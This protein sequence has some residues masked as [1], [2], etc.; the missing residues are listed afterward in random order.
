MCPRKHNGKLLRKSVLLLLLMA[1]PGFVWGQ[2]KKA[3]S[4]PAPRPSAPAQHAPAQHPPAPA[5]AAAPAHGAPARPGNAAPR[6]GTSK[7]AATKPGTTKPGATPA[8]GAPGARNSGTGNKAAGPGVKPAAP[9]NKPGTGTKTAGPGTKPGGSS[10]KS[11]VKQVSLR[12]GGTARVRSNGQIRSVNRNGMH[13]EHNLHGGRTVVS[14]RGGKR[15][16]TTG[17]HGGYVQKSYMTRGGHSYYSRTYYDHGHYR[18]GVY[19]GY[20]YRGYHYYGYHP[21][22]YYNPGF[23][24]WAGRPWGAPVYWGV[25]AWGWGGA[26]WYA[27]YGFT[28][29]ASYPGPAFWLTDYLIAANLQAAYA[30][31]GAG[32]PALPG[33]VNQSEG[34]VGADQ[35]NVST[36]AWNGRQYEMTFN[37][38]HCGNLS[39]VRWNSDGVVLSRVDFNGF[40]ATYTGKLQ[41]SGAIAGN[42]LWVAP[43]TSG[44]VGAWSATF[45]PVAPAPLAGSEPVALSPEVKQAVAEEV[46]AQL[47]AE[48]ATAGQGS[49]GA[50][51]SQS[52]GDE[53][54]PALDPARRTFVVSADLAVDDTD[55]QECSL[56]QGDVLMRIGDTPDSNQKVSVSVATSKNNDCAAGKQ[57]TVAVDD[58][59]EM[60]NRFQEQLDDGMKELASKQGTGKMP[61][62]PDTKTVASDVPPPPPDTTAANDLQQQQ[63]SADQTESEVKKESL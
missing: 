6:P 58:L 8:K 15:I 29:Y 53:V 35:T 19:R 21:G 7:S 51:Q 57:I 26:P 52:N 56:T 41:G 61:K 37:G 46:K 9:G 28:P 12:G 63:A 20:N 34:Q 33:I 47:A 27:Y 16:V 25:G 18:T 1:A 11:S 45:A 13:I 17:Q 39:V 60:R 22:F 54:P 14:E 55:N 59:Q 23:Y 42:V 43:G 48:Q 5:H 24:G 49:S 38:S 36:W 50:Q 2:Q 4:P 10:A 44:S 32:S 62:A 3:P 30:D 40:R 31:V